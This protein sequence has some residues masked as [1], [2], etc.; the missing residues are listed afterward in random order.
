VDT[1]GRTGKKRCGWQ[2]PGRW[3]PIETNKSDSD[4][5]SEKR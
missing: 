3:H 1:R 2:P 4:K 5:Q